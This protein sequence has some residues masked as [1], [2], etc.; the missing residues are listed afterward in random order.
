LDASVLLGLLSGYG[1][2]CSARWVDT[3]TAVR[4]EL[5]HGCY[6]RRYSGADGLSGG[7]GA[8]LSCSFWLAEALA[9]TGSV[10]DATAL[11]D[12]LIML[13]NDVG[14]YAEEVDPVTGAFLGNLPQA[15]SH[16][17]LISAAFGIADL[18]A[19]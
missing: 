1:D 2:A 8:F 14:L 7:E 3:V 9:R 4:R 19:R 13:A 17:S 16:L 10:D 5:G 12:E 11:M 15:L 18:T 6:V